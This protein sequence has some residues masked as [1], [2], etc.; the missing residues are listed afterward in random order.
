MREFVVWVGAI[1][2]VHF[3]RLVNR[4][5]G[6]REQAIKRVRCR[7]DCGGGE[8]KKRPATRDLVEQGLRRGDTFLCG[9]GVYNNH[10]VVI[11]RL[12]Q[13]SLDFAMAKVLRGGGEMRF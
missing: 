9:V 8:Y 10:G 5:S 13:G 3:R 12:Q 4:D 6:G 11:E 7:I 2:A 1:G